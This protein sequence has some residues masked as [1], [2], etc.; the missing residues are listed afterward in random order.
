MNK[1]NIK[2][3][4]LLIPLILLLLFCFVSIF[5]TPVWGDEVVY[6]Y[7]NALNISFFNIIESNSTYSSA[8]TPLPYV[9]GGVVCKINNSIVT[10]RILNY[11][12]FLLLIYYLYKIAVQLNYN[13]WLFVLLII[14]NPYLLRSSFAYYMFN[15]GLLFSIICIYYYFFSKTKYKL[16]ISHL[17]LG[18]AVLSQQWMLIIGF[19][20][21][22]NELTQYFKKILNKKQLINVVLYKLI[23]L[24]PASLLFYCWGGLTHPHFQMHG[25]QPTF[26][27][28]NAVLANFGFVGIFIVIYKIKDIL[29]YKYIPLI[30]IL[31]IVW[32]TIPIHSQVHG[33]GIST[34]VASQLS[35]QIQKYLFIPYQAS[36]ALLIVAGIILF[37]FILSKSE[38][39]FTC[40]IK[41]TILGFIVA[42]MSSVLLGASH[43]FI[44]VP[45]LL[46]IFFPE[47]NENKA[48]GKIVFTQLYLIALFYIIYLSLFVVKNVTL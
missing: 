40:F 45:F 10:L 43:I 27:H 23:F 7:P 15:Y 44:S 24:F 31:P 14:S 33:P 39:N 32:F 37:V 36:M 30:F 12:I 46:I 25:L 42:F 20:L 6:H 21:F 26:E 47:L 5:I 13:P 4:Y 19:A 2:V 29:N 38:S 22:V 35:M 11:F 28:L 48:L 17:F 18:L 1:K 8:Y 34:G 41:Y 16:I 9:L 3:F